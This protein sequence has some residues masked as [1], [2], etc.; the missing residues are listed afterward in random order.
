VATMR[1]MAKSIGQKKEGR[2]SGSTSL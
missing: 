1:D 2:G